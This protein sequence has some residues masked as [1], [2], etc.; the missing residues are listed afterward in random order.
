MKN[1]FTA[2]LLALALIPLNGCSSIESNSKGAR[3]S[4]RETSHNYDNLESSLAFSIDRLA[5][6]R[7]DPGS[8][9]YFLRNLNEIDATV[10]KDRDALKTSRQKLL[11]NGREH[12]GLLDAES[13]KFTDAELALKVSRD[14][15]SLGAEYAA[16]DKASASVTDSMDIAGKYA[17]DIR[18]M[19]GINGAAAGVD[20]CI[21]TV[22]KMED[23]L[24]AAKRRIPDARAAL[25]NLRRKLPAPASAASGE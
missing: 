7:R 15:E 1:Q 16:Y 11:E 23:A 6:L 8:A 24:E 21:G 12:A 18:R 22:R 5:S 13:A 19:M 2:I 25:E 4:A 20:N 9:E 14:A 3:A 17:D 10:A